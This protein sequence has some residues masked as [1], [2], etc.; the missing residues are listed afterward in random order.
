MALMLTIIRCCAH[1]VRLVCGQ[2]EYTVTLAAHARRGLIVFNVYSRS[3]YI[4]NIYE[5]TLS[6]Y[7]NAISH[8]PT[9][10][11]IGESEGQAMPHPSSGVLRGRSAGGGHA[12]LQALPKEALERP[13]SQ[14]KHL[15]KTPL[16]PKYCIRY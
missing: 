12:L 10:V 7:A 1:I 6:I 8:R 15:R 13:S 9:P 5:Y 11:Y 2:A 4:D 3:L 16:S 14:T